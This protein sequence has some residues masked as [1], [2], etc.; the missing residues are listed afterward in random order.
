M[1]S[2][3]S[4]VSGQ[5]AVYDQ[6][7]LIANNLANLSTAGFKAERLIFE[8]ALSEVR[9]PESALSSEIEDPSS[10]TSRFFTGN[11]GSY[12]DFTQGPIE[13]TGNP[14]DVALEGKGFFV[15]STPEGERYTRAGQFHKNADGLLVSSHGHP[16]L[17]DGGEIALP[18]GEPI[19]G[20]DGSVTVAG[21]FVARLRAV[22]INPQDL[23]REA[24]Q[25]FVLRDG[26]T[27]T[28]AAETRFIG[29]AVEQSNV[30]AA[31]EL[32]DMIAAARSFEA[33]QKSRE[34][35]GRMSRA[36]Q[37]AFGRS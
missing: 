3:Y 18:A 6:M 26:G 36:R 19:I 9:A 12:T 35:D 13:M 15:V 7:Q 34:S 14:Y 29:S 4:A 1:S 2:V 20:R 23:T 24:G 5:K 37:E 32:T 16:V 30:N 8:Q 28:D 21:Q 33:L 10:M 31:R 25:L 11:A 17:G 27:V 22:E